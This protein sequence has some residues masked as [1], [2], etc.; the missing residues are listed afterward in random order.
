MRKLSKILLFVV[1]CFIA[2]IIYAGEKQQ[3]AMEKITE[4]LQNKRYQPWTW[5]FYG[6][7]ITHGAVHTFS[8][9]SFVELFHERLRGECGKKSDVVINSG[10]SGYSSFELLN[11]HVY[12]RNIK[13]YNPQVVFLLIGCNDITHAKNKGVQDFRERLEKLVVRLEADGAI[14]VLQTY[15]LF[16]VVDTDNSIY[17]NY[18][19]RYNEQHEYNQQIREVAEKFDLILIDH[20]KYWQERCV[21]DQ[22]LKNWLSDY[23][24]PNALGHFQMAR[25]IMQ[26]FNLYNGKSNTGA[27]VPAPRGVVFNKK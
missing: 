26:K 5:V 17:K 4:H 10:S 9:R 20:A 27:I 6:D 7:S 15:N 14:V 8:N 3:Q 12:N 24:H 2:T 22:I 13:R 19:R 25:L 21:S 11:E 1:G 18:I 16:R 23:I